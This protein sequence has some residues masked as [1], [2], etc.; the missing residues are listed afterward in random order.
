MT[1]GYLSVLFWQGLENFIL[2]KDP[3]ADGNYFSKTIFAIFWTLSDFF[4]PFDIYSQ[5]GWQ[6][7]LLSV[8]STF[9]DET[10]Q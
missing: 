4:Q 10:N 7:S 6:N 9:L 3:S 8:H 1:F 5:R 2:P